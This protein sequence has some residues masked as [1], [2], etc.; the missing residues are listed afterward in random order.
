MKK[1]SY[2]LDENEYENNLKQL[3][4]NTNDSFAKYFQRYELRKSKWVHCFMPGNKL[5][6]NNMA[7]ESYHKTLKYCYL[8]GKRNKRADT[9][10]IQLRKL[11]ADFAYLIK[12]DNKRGQPSFF[13]RKTTERRAIAK[14]EKFTINGNEI[15]V[16]KI[17]NRKN[18]MLIK[19]HLLS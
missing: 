17:V 19:S 13:S 3:Y 12:V 15:Q 2:S 1:I 8:N 14:S 5:L 11:A 16:I 7:I 6:K 9:L 18:F 4:D 10:I